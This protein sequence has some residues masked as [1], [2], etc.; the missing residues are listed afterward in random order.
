M[1]LVI[2]KVEFEIS[3][4]NTFALNNIYLVLEVLADIFFLRTKWL[5]CE[6]HHLFGRGGQVEWGP[7]FNADISSANSNSLSEMQFGKS[8]RGGGVEG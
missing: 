7:D 1:W 8:L 6:V 2:F 5:Y 4:P 3:G